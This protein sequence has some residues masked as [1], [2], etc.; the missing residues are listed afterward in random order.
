MDKQYVHVLIS[1]S[2]FSD[3]FML[4]AK[5][6]ES[7][8]KEI[9]E[10]VAAYNDIVV[11]YSSAISFDDGFWFVYP[12]NYPE[13]MHADAATK[14]ATVVEQ[15]N[16]LF[17]VVSHANANDYIAEAFLLSM[18]KSQSPLFQHLDNDALQLMLSVYTKVTTVNA[19]VAQRYHNNRTVF[20]H[21]LKLR[22]EGKEI[23]QKSFLTD[24][25]EFNRIKEKSAPDKYMFSD[26]SKRVNEMFGKYN[27]HQKSSK[28]TD[29]MR[30]PFTSGLNG[31]RSEIDNDDSS[32][33]LNVKHAAEN[34][35]RNRKEEEK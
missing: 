11:K 30:N 34:A 23:T 25:Y 2:W 35:N 31:W 15:C 16:G 28:L 7:D 19:D 9:F 32:G 3:M 17:S 18:T 4:Q 6:E 20:T 24:K 29:I 26:A 21:A 33:Y 10:A 13:T 27:N 1:N 14:F 8:A 22:F 5:I 12:R